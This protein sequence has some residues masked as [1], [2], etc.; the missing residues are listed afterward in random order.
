[1][2]SNRS[3]IVTDAIAKP[4]NES[5]VQTSIQTLANACR[6]TYGDGEWTGGIGGVGYYVQYAMFW[7]AKL[8]FNATGDVVVVLPFTL[9]DSIVT[10]TDIVTM[11]RR[12]IHVQSGNTLSITGL[13]GKTILEI[14]FAKN[15][16]G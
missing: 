8:S 3:T 14:N 11:V 5:E 10:L 1:M 2:A 9:L 16:R 4:I 12:Y 7:D 6:G 15:G 13:T